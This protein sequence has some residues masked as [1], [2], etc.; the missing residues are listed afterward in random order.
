MSSEE[1]RD[2]G[3]DADFTAGINETSKR[4]RHLAV[5]Y[6][7]ITKKTKTNI[8]RPGVGMFGAD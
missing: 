8:F 3:T 2:D 7:N 6:E 5:R 4:L 1:R